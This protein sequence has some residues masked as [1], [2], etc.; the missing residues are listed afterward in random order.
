MT[1][2]CPASIMERFKILAFLPGMFELVEA[3]MAVSLDGRPPRFSGIPTCGAF[4]ENSD[5][6]WA[7]TM[8]ITTGSLRGIPTTAG[9]HGSP[10][11]K[12]AKIALAESANSLGS[13]QYQ[14][15][16]AYGECCARAEDFRAG[17]AN[18][19]KGCRLAVFNTSWYAEAGNAYRA[20]HRPTSAPKQILPMSSWFILQ[21]RLCGTGERAQKYLDF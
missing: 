10:I 19:R 13:H 15:F 8:K 21:R 14:A 2:A 3:P 5:R 11:T 1:A 4:H 12:P 17:G 16:T 20:L 6:F 7:V 9:R 18:E